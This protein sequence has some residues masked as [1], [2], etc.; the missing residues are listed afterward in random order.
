MAAKFQVSH[1]IWLTTE[2]ARIEGIILGIKFWG[3]VWDD[4]LLLQEL[5]AI[6]LPYTLKQ[7]QELNDELHNRGIV[8]DLVTPVPAPAPTP[9]AET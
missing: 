1:K 5:N 4:K 2:S 9:I 8:E 6:G 3:R 7:V